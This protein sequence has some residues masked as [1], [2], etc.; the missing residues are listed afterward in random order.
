VSPVRYEPGFYIQE[1]GIL[2]SHRRDNLKPYLYILSLFKVLQYYS[3][4]VHELLFCISLFCALD[5]FMV[6]FP[7]RLR[8]DFICNSHTAD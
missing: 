4:S 3:D 8:M 6:L 7:G 5:F 1:D 2:H